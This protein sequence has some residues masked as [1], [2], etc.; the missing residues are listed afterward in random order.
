MQNTGNMAD[1]F[2]V[3]DGLLLRFHNIAMKKTDLLKA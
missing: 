3:Q 2:V 1:N